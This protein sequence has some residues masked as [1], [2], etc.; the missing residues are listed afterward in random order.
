M[1]DKLKQL[2]NLK[3]QAQNL[4]SSLAQERVETDRQG[5]K[6]VM[7]GNQK[8]ISLDIVSE[9]STTELETRLPEIFNETVDKAQKIIASK[10]Q[11]GGFNLPGF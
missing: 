10:M 8:V 9:L 2:K 11:S 6:L 4:Q 7:D 5:I 3:D 1:L